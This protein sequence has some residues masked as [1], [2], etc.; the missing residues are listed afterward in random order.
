LQ[1]TFYQ[2]DSETSSNVTTH[3]FI[4]QVVVVFPHL[5][6]K[7]KAG[8]RFKF[9]KESSR[10]GVSTTNSNNFTTHVFHQMSSGHL[11]AMEQCCLVC[12]EKLT[13]ISSQ[14]LATAIAIKRNISEW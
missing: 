14:S 11:G 13:P 10:L 1:Q 8:D 6:L 9:K 4:K 3:T 5:E 12:K 2:D 7:H